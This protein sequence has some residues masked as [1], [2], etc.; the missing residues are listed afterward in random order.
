MHRSGDG[1]CVGADGKHFWLAVR[2][3]KPSNILPYADE[4][5]VVDVFISGGKLTKVRGRPS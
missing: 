1:R 5:E 3:P 4:I 2:N